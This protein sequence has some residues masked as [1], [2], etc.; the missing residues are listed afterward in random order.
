MLKV[1]EALD[2][3]GG[4]VY[5]ASGSF[6]STRTHA[7]VSDTLQGLREQYSR[8]QYLGIVSSLINGVSRASSS[9][10]VMIAIGGGALGLAGYSTYE[11]LGTTGFVRGR[12][13][14]L[15]S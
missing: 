1:I 12:G 5:E 3:P 9:R 4:F 15:R 8:S 6:E 2:P 13:A 14:E 11:W 10:P 7:I